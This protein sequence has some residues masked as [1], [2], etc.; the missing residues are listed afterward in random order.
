M[1][2]KEVEVEVML[3]VRDLWSSGR[4]RDEERQDRDRGNAP[5]QSC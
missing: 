1:V 3:G 5:R 2:L 4:R